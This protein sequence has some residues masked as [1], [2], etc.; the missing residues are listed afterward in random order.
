MSQFLHSLKD[1]LIIVDQEMETLPEQL[2]SIAA[3]L[4]RGRLRKLLLRLDQSCNELYNKKFDAERPKGTWLP[5]ILDSSGFREITEEDW[6]RWRQ[7]YKSRVWVVIGKA[8]VDVID[9]AELIK[10]S[11]MTVMQTTLLFQQQGFTV[12]PWKR[13]LELLDEIGKL[14]GGDDD[15]GGIIGPS[16]T[17]L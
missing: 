8:F 14:I 10:E 12:L 7:N 3:R 1:E 9:L 11:K 6:S 16:E 4:D 15:Q 17:K 2:D 13:Y 5:W